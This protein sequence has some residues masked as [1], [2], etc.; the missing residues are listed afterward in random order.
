MLVLKQNTYFILLIVLI[1]LLT[2][3]LLKKEEISIIQ[4]DGKGYYAYLPALLIHQENDYV[5]T[6]IAERK[7][8][9]ENYNPTYLNKTNDG[10]VFNQYF[11]GV[12]VL[13][14]PFFL[15]AYFLSYISDS[16]LDGYSNTF[17]LFFFLGGI[18]YTILGLYFF[19][20]SLLIY[21]SENKKT[22]QLITFLMYFSSPLL[23]YSLEMVS[24]SHI[25]SFSLFGV[26]SYLVLSRKSIRFF[27]TKLGIVL[28]L[29]FLLRPTNILIIFILPFLLQDWNATRQFFQE[30]IHNK[31]KRFWLAFIPFLSIISIQFFLWKWQTGKWLIN[32]YKGESFDFI[33]PHFFDALFSFRIGLF[34]HTPILILSFIGIIYFL[35]K[36]KFAA[37][38][39]LVYFF[40]NTW[41]I[42]S[43]WCWDYES[44]FGNRPFTEHLFF[45]LFPIILLVQKH[46][47]IGFIMLII[48]ALLGFNRFYQFR[49]R[50]IPVQRFSSD[51]YFKSLFHYQNN[52]RFQFT[53]SCK[54]IGSLVKTRI[55]FEQ[56]EKKL[57]T[58]KDE[59]GLG[60]QLA[61]NEKNSAKS[62]FITIELD[63][64]VS[65][66]PFSNVLLA[67]DASDKDSDK[68]FYHTFELYNDQLEAKDDWKHLIFEQ[69]LDDYEKEYNE[70]KIYIWNKGKKEFEVKNIKYSISSYN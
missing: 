46:K 60:A 62:Y 42:S 49:E 70:I 22:I 56:K 59:F 52:E 8:F 47:K 63:K 50:I 44:Y 29:I 40:I 26:F 28:G 53:R 66:T 23:V 9:G 35:K 67:I 11:S 61:I 4:S 38:S 48:F 16:P 41:V 37:I 24:Y 58:P 3:S 17:Q 39:W 1:G 34:I 43:W 45:L 57:I 5:Q 15:T 2:I 55:I 33:H 65:K 36:N 12:A 20:K 13:Q 6:N 7:Y 27:H 14:M 31:M 54:P 30:M 10:K 32:S 68:R 69:K 18:F 19:Q 25:Y 21:F 64:K 51:T